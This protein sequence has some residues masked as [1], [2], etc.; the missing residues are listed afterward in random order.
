MQARQLTIHNIGDTFAFGLGVIELPQMVEMLATVGIIKYGWPI[1]GTERV[2]D[3]PKAPEQVDGRVGTCPQ[4]S[5]QS[6]RFHS[7]ISSFFDVLEDP[8]VF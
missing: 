6:E 1:W 5:F 2:N 4:V 8:T 3:W 7:S